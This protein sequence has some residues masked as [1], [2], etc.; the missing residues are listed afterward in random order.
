MRSRVL[1]T[2]ILRDLSVRFAAD[3]VG[4]PANGV[5]AGVVAKDEALAK[6]TSGCGAIC[7]RLVGILLAG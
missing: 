1:P 7:T 5:A 3:P 4:V 6:E 2:G